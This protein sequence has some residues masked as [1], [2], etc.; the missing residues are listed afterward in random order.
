MS[1]FCLLLSWIALLWVVMYRCK[2][3]SFLWFFQWCPVFKMEHLWLVKQLS[4]CMGLPPEFDA[5]T[6]V[7]EG[8]NWPLTLCWLVIFIYLIQVRVCWKDETS[9][10]KTPSSD[11]P[12]CKSLGHFL[13]WRLIREGLAQ[14]GW[15]CPWAGGYEWPME[16]KPVSSNVPSWPLLPLL[17]PLLLEFLSDSLWP[18]MNK[19]PQPASCFWAWCFPQP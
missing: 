8:E 16:S 1:C 19:P 3:I 2:L 4:G 7:V 17:L 9:A 10:K 12:G 15:C 11:L 6:Q 14:C 5:G 13:D 18:G